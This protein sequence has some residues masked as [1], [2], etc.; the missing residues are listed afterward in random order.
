VDVP[1]PQRRR[2]DSENGAGF[3]AKAPPPAKIVDMLAVSVSWPSLESVERS[4]E[5]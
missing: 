3:G 1:L 5:A 4:S 2:F